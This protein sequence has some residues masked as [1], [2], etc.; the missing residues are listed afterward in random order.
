VEVVALRS[1]AVARAPL[2]EPK[3]VRARE[4][5]ASARGPA[6]RAWIGGERLDVPVIERARLAPGQRFEG[7]ALVEEF[8]G[9]TLVP[10][11]VSA[12]MSAGGHLL[13]V[14]GG[15]RG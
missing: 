12:R 6:R 11:E 2:P 9:T 10:P 13:L 1:R 5:P 8:S 15:G 4:L 3:R 14:R 7:P